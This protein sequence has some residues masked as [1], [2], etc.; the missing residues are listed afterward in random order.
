MIQERIGDLLEIE[1]AGKSFYVVAL[2][3]AVMFGG[4]I[5]FAFHND[6]QKRTVSRLEADRSGFN[7]CADLLLPKRQGRVTRLDRY[8]DVT[9]FWRSK[10]VKATHEY[11]LGVNAKEWFIYNIGD[12][13]GVAH[14][15]CCQA[16]LG[17]PSG[18]GQQLLQLRPCRREGVGAIH[19]GSE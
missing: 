14:C 17:V 11:R 4:N 15:A 19:A 3:K 13:G 9:P 10:Y 16:D 8:E 18:D 12:L 2:T 6:G 5:I 7:I 1:E